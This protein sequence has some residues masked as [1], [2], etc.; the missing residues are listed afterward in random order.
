MSKGNLPPDEPYKKRPYKVGKGRPPKH[1]QFKPG[2]SGNPRGRPKGSKK[3]SKGFE[4][5]FDKLLLEEAARSIE[6][7]E[8]GK[9]AK[10]ATIQAVVRVMNN[11]ALKGN[12]SAAK[13]VTGMVQNA[14]SS[15]VDK[16][17]SEAKR[18]YEYKQAME[19][20]IRLNK[21]SKNFKMPLP[22]PD[23][24]FIDD[25]T[26]EV[27]IKGPKDRKA[28]G[29]WKV[30][31]YQLVQMEVEAML[32]SS[33]PALVFCGHDIDAFIQEDE[34][35]TKA[36]HELFR[37]RVPDDDPFWLEY[38]PGYKRS[39]IDFYY[40]YGPNFSIPEMSLVSIGS[41][42]RRTPEFTEHDRE[43]L[44]DYEYKNSGFREF[45]RE[46]L[47]NIMGVDWHLRL[48]APMHVM[49]D[50]ELDK[51][52][53]HYEKGTFNP[54]EYKLEAGEDALFRDESFLQAYMCWLPDEERLEGLR[55]YWKEK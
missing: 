6:I 29:Y 54:D 44:R 55:V 10:I 13:L 45:M 27:T 40:Y 51:M 4:A 9:P 26:Y 19:E 33:A 31:I 32:R 24:V 53:Y 21:R 25:D 1:G 48:D 11:K 47:A 22:H 30:V 18:A 49:R 14:E 36:F 50:I 17:Y 16:L 20:Y 5:Q 28:L 38:A 41:Q 46:K 2:Q 42:E 7:Q 12:V 15:L 8:N 3:K 35:M 34:A 37:D 23:H 43:R 39:L 52:R